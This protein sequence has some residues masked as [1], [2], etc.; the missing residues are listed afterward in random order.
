[1]FY[2]KMK[3]ICAQEKVIKLEVL[4]NNKEEMA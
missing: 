1:M 2:M 3:K 4:M